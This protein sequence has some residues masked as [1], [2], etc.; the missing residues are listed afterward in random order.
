MLIEAMTEY[1]LAVVGREGNIS[2]EVEGTRDG[3]TSHSPVQE[4]D[5]SSA[6]STGS[7][8]RVTGGVTLLSPE[9]AGA[10]PSSAQPLLNLDPPSPSPPGRRDALKEAT[11]GVKAHCAD[12]S[13][14]PSRLVNESQW[15]QISKQLQVSLTLANSDSQTLRWA[16]ELERADAER[17]TP[18]WPGRPHNIVKHLDNFIE[19]VQK[20]KP[21]DADEV[22]DHLSV[23]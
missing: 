3:T 8:E 23:L 2:G 15:G 19:L 5:R 22:Y 17:D 13:L 16:G 14:A 10:A 20:L 9:P 18:A 4:D 1:Q 7:S 12:A 11:D 6:G 21:A